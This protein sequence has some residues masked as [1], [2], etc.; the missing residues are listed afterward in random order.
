MVV[1]IGPQYLEMVTDQIAKAGEPCHLIGEVVD[2]NGK[3]Q[4]V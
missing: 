4:F 2:G 3:V 1:I